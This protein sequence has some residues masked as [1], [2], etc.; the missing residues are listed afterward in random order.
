MTHNV[1]VPVVMCH[2]IAHVSGQP[3]IFISFIITNDRLGFF[4]HK[5]HNYFNLL[6][7]LIYKMNSIIST[8][9]QDYFLNLYVSIY[10]NYENTF[11]VYTSLKNTL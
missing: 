8:R 5:F 1:I 6:V 2:E 7:L 9:L 3:L 11:H 10:S 4:H